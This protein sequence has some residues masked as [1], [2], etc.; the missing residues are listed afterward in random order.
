MRNLRS[1]QDNGKTTG[2]SGD[3][4]GSVAASIVTWW[5]N[6]TGSIR[7][8]PRFYSKTNS[9]ETMAIGQSE[10]MNRRAEFLET[11]AGFVSDSINIRMKSLAKRAKMRMRGKSAKNNVTPPHKNSG[12]I[13][14]FTVSSN[15]NS[16]KRRG[17]RLSVV[18]SHKSESFMVRKVNEFRQLAS[19]SNKNKVK[20]SIKIVTVNP[21]E[22]RRVSTTSL[23]RQREL[24][25]A[26]SAELQ[27]EQDREDLLKA[28]MAS[29][30]PFGMA[31]KTNSTRYQSSR[32]RGGARRD[33]TRSSRRKSPGSGFEPRMVPFQN[34]SPEPDE[35]TMLTHSDIDNSMQLVDYED[36]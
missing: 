27:A 22:Q 28:A 23:K 7:A 35:M 12:K 4:K 15:R 26:E 11:K 3:R 34:P 25:E 1:S 18:D 19:R 16:S 36:L 13:K 10:D 20:P 2:D 6:K 5:T 29:T 9:V 21:K 14:S 8:Q 33:R 17:R 24:A 31:N 30:K 32:Q